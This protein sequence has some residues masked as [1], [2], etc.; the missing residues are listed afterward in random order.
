[1]AVSLSNL[2]TSATCQYKNKTYDFT[3]HESTEDTDSEFCIFHDRCYL[4]DENYKKHTE[5]IAEKFKER[6]SEYSSNHKPLKFIGYCL[7]DISFKNEKFTEALNFSEATFYGATRAT[8][9]RGATFSNEAH[10][11]EA[12]FS[13]KAPFL[14]LH[15]PKQTFIELHSP[16]K[17]VSL[18]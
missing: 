14:E 10:F 16:K 15:S 17:Q 6:L 11:S 13:N 4:K 8:S 1:L 12:T 2:A 7:P 3:C 5:K 9:F 18:G